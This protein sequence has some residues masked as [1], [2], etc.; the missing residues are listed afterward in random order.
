MLRIRDAETGR[1]S[2]VDT[3]SSGF[4]ETYARFVERRLAE[5]QAVFQ[6]SGT[7]HVRI[8]TD[9]DYIPALKR[10]FSQRR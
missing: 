4:T 6:K 7:A 8:F 2:L 1:V 3:S 5:Q 10:L 9:E